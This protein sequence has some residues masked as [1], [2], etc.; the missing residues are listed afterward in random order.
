MSTSMDEARAIAAEMAAERDG[1]ELPEVDRLHEFERLESEVR[2]CEVTVANREASIKLLADI[3]DRLLKKCGED[4][5]VFK[6]T[7]GECDGGCADMIAEW[8]MSDE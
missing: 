7:L 4:C 1:Q 5:P 6:T 2:S 8:A 3:V